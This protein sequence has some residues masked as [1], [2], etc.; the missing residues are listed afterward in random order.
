MRHVPGV[1]AWLAIATL[2]NQQPGVAGEVVAAKS[3]TI[4]PTGPRSGDAGSKYFNIEGKDKGNY[5]SFGI[6]VFDMPKKFDASKVK[7]ATLTL[8]QSIPQFAANG[9]IKILLAPDLDPATDLKFDSSADNGVG[10]Q[11]KTLTE[12]GSGR[13]KKVKTGELQSFTL[14]LE[15]ACK[16]RIAKGGRLCLVIVPADST[17]AAT[18]FGANRKDKGNSPKLMMD[19]P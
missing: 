16:V 14:K 8:V 3:L 15:D 17:V 5:A 9:E 19:L 6:L 4:Q 10:D 13:F 11:I 12:L 7:G 2:L 1:I 18:Y